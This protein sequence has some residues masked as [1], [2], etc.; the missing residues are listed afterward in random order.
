MANVS[1]TGV[2]SLWAVE[3]ADNATTLVD[4][5][6]QGTLPQWFHCLGTMESWDKELDR[7]TWVVVTE[8]GTFAFRRMYFQGRKHAWMLRGNGAESILVI[9]T[10]SLCLYQ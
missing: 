9:C 4:V 7:N 6:V 2:S 5:G 8:R 3:E 1:L 10:K